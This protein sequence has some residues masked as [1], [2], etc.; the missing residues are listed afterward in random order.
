MHVCRCPTPGNSTFAYILVGEQ[1]DGDDTQRS[2]AVIVIIITS[3]LRG[4]L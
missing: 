2:V 1:N 4:C 3:V